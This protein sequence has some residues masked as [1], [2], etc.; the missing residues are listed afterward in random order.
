MQVKNILGYKTCKLGNR[1]HGSSREYPSHEIWKLRILE[2][3]E[4][5]R[6]KKCNL[7]SMVIG[8]K[9]IFFICL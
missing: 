7:G 5:P 4:C 8:S 6:F 9:G 2:V 3:K 1:E